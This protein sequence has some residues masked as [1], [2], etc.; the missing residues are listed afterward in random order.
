M[1]KPSP[2]PER[3]TLAVFALVAAAAKSGAAESAWLAAARSIAS[4]VMDDGVPTE[5][6]LHLA[7]DLHGLAEQPDACAKDA[8]VTLRVAAEM[9]SHAS[10][11]RRQAEAKQKAFRSVEVVAGSPKSRRVLKLLA[12]ES[13]MR[14]TDIAAQLQC[15]LPTISRELRRMRGI[16]LVD[17]TVPPNDAT[18]G[19][20]R[21]YALT[22]RGR[23]MVEKELPIRQSARRLEPD[24]ATSN[25][26][27]GLDLV[28][29]PLLDV[30]H[31]SI[32]V[33]ADAVTDD[34]VPS[35]RKAL[36]ARAGASPATP[37]DRQQDAVPHGESG[38]G[39]DF[40][41]DEAWRA[42]VSHDR[43]LLSEQV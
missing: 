35:S 2:P 41:I 39:G 31:Y 42:R 43:Q 37:K 38:E 36:W 27:D 1:P 14:P 40:P 20:Y 13:G 8:C 7:K 5:Q 29:K 4:T 21:Y 23:K 28:S 12:V 9:F 19:R 22:D 33:S 26:G 18:D 16:G 24:C 3:S 6:Y 11:I 10:R 34:V 15:D 32:S 30:S 17:V 25:S